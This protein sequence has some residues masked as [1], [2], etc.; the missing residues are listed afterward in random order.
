MGLKVSAWAWW[1]EDFSGS[2]RR[3]KY[4]WPKQGQSS[5]IDLFI[6]IRPCKQ[7]THHIVFGSVCMCG[8]NYLSMQHCSVWPQ[9]RQ[10]NRTPRFNRIRCSIVRGRPYSQRWRQRGFQRGTPS[11]PRGLITED[12]GCGLRCT[13]QSYNYLSRGITN[14]ITTLSWVRPSQPEIF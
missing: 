2:Q 10:T 9:T 11:Q 4:S 13:S 3:S 5:W 6:L 8:S 1:P 14:P 12:S 7:A